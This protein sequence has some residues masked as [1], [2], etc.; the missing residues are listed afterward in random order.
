[1]ITRVRLSSGAA[2]AQVLYIQ[3]TGS[4]VIAGPY[5][6]EAAVGRGFMFDCFIP[7]AP[8]QDINFTTDEDGLQTVE[9][10]WITKKV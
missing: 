7:V 1:M 9:F 5:Y 8:N 10:E 6:L 2:V 4:G 3:S